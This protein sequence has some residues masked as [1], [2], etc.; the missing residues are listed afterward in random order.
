MQKWDTIKSQIS[1]FDSYQLA[2]ISNFKRAFSFLWATG[3]YA[4]V[5]FF[6][7]A[8]FITITIIKINLKLVIKYILKNK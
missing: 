8:K 5:W 7:L 1:H 2:K 6:S 4:Q 3:E